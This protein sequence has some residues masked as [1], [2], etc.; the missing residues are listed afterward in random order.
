MMA[1]EISDE[2]TA[3]HGSAGPDKAPEMA[4]DS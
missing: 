2:T 3:D 4:L 1:V